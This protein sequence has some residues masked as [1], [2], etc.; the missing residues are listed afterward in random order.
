VHDP[1]WL[2]IQTNN[3]PVPCNPQLHVLFL[4]WMFWEQAQA[5]SD[6]LELSVSW[7]HSVQ[8]ADSTGFIASTLFCM[9]SAVSAE[10]NDWEHRFAHDSSLVLLVA[11]TLFIL[12]TSTAFLALGPPNVPSRLNRFHE[13]VNKSMLVFW[14]VT[15]DGLVATTQRF[16]ATYCLHLPGFCRLHY[17][18]LRVLLE[19]IM[20]AVLVKKLTTLQSYKTRKFITVFARA[21]HLSYLLNIQK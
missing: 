10:G 13:N 12:E 4:C 6:C 16:W 18:E 2:S 3:F 9:V 19:K 20:V 15:S 1:C 17:M 5:G 7:L 21:R 11:S 14:V 8:R